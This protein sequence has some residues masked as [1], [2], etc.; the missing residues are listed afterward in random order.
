MRSCDYWCVLPT[1]MQVPA[2]PSPEYVRV[3]LRMV[4][5][6]ESNTYRL[7]RTTDVPLD[8]VMLRPTVRCDN[9]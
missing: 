1:L 7:T 5:L 6:A 3:A 8:V 2:C 4:M 9:T